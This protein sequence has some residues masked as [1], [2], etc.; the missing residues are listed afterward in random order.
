MVQMVSI[1]KISFLF[2]GDGNLLLKKVFRN[3]LKLPEPT[4]FAMEGE[5]VNLHLKRVLVP[6][7]SMSLYRT[8]LHMDNSR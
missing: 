5:K 3:V 1:T 6:S 7:L 4:I 8:V 2:L